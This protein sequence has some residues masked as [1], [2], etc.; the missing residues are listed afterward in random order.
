MSSHTAKHIVSKA[1]LAWTDALHA[2][3]LARTTRNAWD[4]GSYVRWA[5]N[6]TWTAFEGF[7]SESLGAKRIGNRFKEEVDKAVAELRYSPLNWGNGIW[8]QVLKVY[9]WRKSLT[10]LGSTSLQ[11]VEVFLSCARADE[12]I[13]TLRAA[14]AALAAHCSMSVPLWAEDNADTGW[15]GPGTNS[16]PPS[17][18]LTTKIATEQDEKLAIGYVTERGCNWAYILGAQEDP[19][20]RLGELLRGIIVSVEAVVVY[21]GIDVKQYIPL[22]TR[23]F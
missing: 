15:K 21:Q 13:N 6:S 16:Y 19:Q 10:H 12:A 11:E 20:Q 7:I 22:R 3:E 8:Q 17:L 4:R 1:S 23:G 14:I 18:L 5:V 9:G 2:R